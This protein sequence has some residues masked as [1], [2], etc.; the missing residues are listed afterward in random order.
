VYTITKKLVATSQYGCIDSAFSVIDIPPADDF[1][2]AISTID[3][4]GK[5][6]VHASFTLCNNFKRGTIPAGLQVTFYD[7]DP[8]YSGAHLLGPVFITGS[9]GPAQCASFAHFFKRTLPVKYLPSSNDNGTTIPL[10]LPNDKT[11][12][13]KN[14]SNNTTSITY[15]PFDVNAGTLRRYPSSRATTLQLSAHAAPE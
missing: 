10:L 5:D 14:Y 4:A 15:I 6:S 9:S 13:E 12:L 1:T 7:A 2:I 8:Q 3:C 11:F